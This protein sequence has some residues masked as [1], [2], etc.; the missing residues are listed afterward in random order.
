MIHKWLVGIFLF[1][2]F[3]ACT[4]GGK[5]HSVVAGEPALVPVAYAQGFTVSR[6]D[7]H[8]EIEVLD[9]W[10]STRIL[11]RYLLVDRNQ[12]L[13]NPLPKG[14]L[15][16]TPAKQLVC[17]SSVICGALNEL[18]ALDEVIGVCEPEYIDIPFIKEGLASGRVA[19]L[20]QSTSPNIE[21]MIEMNA[22]AIIATS[23]ENSNYGAAEKLGIPIIECSDYMETTPLGRA[24]W[25]RFYGFFCGKENL[26]DSIF[27]E[28][29]KRYLALKELASTVTHRPSVVSE[30]KYGSTWY[31]PGGNSYMAHFYK[32][33]GASY[34]FSD[35]LVTGTVP[36]SFEMVFDR[37][38]HA[39]FWLIKYNTS[40]EMSYNDLQR[41]YPPYANFEA[42]TK[43]NIYACN[44]GGVPYYEELPVHPDYLLEEFVW[45][46][47]PELLPG[48]KPRYF[49]KMKE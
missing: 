47:H 26:A 41:E 10:D 1:F 22:N 29:E 38:A 40:Y 12:P 2:S 20:G 9:P 6:L 24:E 11:Q 16:R 44:T 35:L 23:F 7:T 5:N 3:C 36:Y 19:D 37:A 34:V 48:Y 32:D 42:F 4:N 27:R 39:D 49:R 14:T 13:P 43:R 28:T 46:F 30:K 8:T 18:D 15:V 33:A 45:L 17:Y 25:I 31:V 21:K